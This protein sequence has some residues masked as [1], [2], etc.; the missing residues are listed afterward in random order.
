MARAT[1]QRSTKSRSS[2]DFGESKH[3]HIEYGSTQGGWDRGAATDFAITTVNVPDRLDTQEVRARAAAADRAPSVRRFYLSDLKRGF[4]WLVWLALIG[5]LAW[6]VTQVVPPLRAAIS[7]AGVES[8]MSKVLGAPVSVR[9]TEI[10]YMPSPRLVVTDMTVQS[11]FRLPQVSV[12]FNWRDAMRGLQAASWVLGEARVA[13]MTLEGQEALAL[14][15]SLQKASGLPAAVSVVR[16]ESVEF[17]GIALLPGRYEAVIRRAINQQNFNAVSLKRLD[18]SGQ[19]D[20]EVTPAS[21]SGASNAKFALF[22]TGW[23]APFGP[24]VAWNEAT[25]QGEFRAEMIK[26]DSYSVGTR[27]G[28]LNGAASLSSDGRGWKLSGNLRGPDLNVEELLAFLSGAPAEGGPA[29]GPA[30]LRGTARFDL[31]VAGSGGSV[32]DALQR[33]TVSGPVTVA[34]AAIS[35]VNFGIA[36]TQGDV[37]G[38]GGVTR[39]SDLDLEVTGTSSGVALRNIAGRAGGLRVVG[40]VNVDRK[41]ELSGALRSEV[42]SPRGVASVQTRVG[43]TVT[44][45]SYR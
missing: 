4:R 13:P 39:F 14:L 22:A 11:G 19:L 1:K 24:A 32:A 29:R 35:G 34:G 21:A 41:L 31:A 43:G 37:N 38:A 10:R 25:A 3:S 6:G 40:A 15:R 45:P 18:A 17:P 7:P 23:T 5:G 27:F 42:M 8:H 9:S 12:H 33:A 16:F 36:A 20:I 28:N 26:V 2:D 44:A 30:P